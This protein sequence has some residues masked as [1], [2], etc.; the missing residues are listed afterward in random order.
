M[1]LLLA[2]LLAPTA[3]AA[4]VPT[5]AEEAQLRAGEVVVRELPTTNGGVRVVAFVD[6]HASPDAVWGALLDF[7]ARRTSNP[8]VRSIDYYR[9]STA[10]DVWVRWE[11]SKF[12]VDIVYHNHYVID[13][14]SGRL[15]HQLDPSQTNDLVESTGAYQLGTSPMGG[16]WTRLTYEIESDFGRALPGF[17]QSWMSSSG[18]RDFM[19]ELARRAASR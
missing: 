11:V 13:R 18:T 12:G 15:L 19:A 8:A 2:T 16:G 1:W 7:P 10:S 3:G 6:V 5:A 17:I 14:T 9:P 4:Q